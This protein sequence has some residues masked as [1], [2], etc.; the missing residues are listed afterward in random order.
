MMYR[1]SFY[2][3]CAV[4]GWGVSEV[5]AAVI[6]REPPIE[7]IEARAIESSVEAGQP[8]TIL[9][10]VQRSRICRVMSANRYIVDKDGIN[11]AIAT[12]E[13]ARTRPG[14]E[15]YDRKIVVPENVPPGPA[16]YFIRLQYGC[17]WFQVLF[18]PLIVESPH[19]DFLVKPAN[20]P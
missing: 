9:F 2:L 7:Y 1:M 4:I 6:D 14:R 11:Y 20:P 8:I 15:V 5:V 12:Y 10:D 17:S 18:R 3:L 19:V 13:V 16:S